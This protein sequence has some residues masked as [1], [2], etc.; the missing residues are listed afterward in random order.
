ME[1]A[2]CALH[3]RRHRPPA[4]IN[5][6][7][8]HNADAQYTVRLGGW[9]YGRL[10]IC[11][12]FGLYQYRTCIDVRHRGDVSMK[13]KYLLVVNS[14]FCLKQR[15]GSEREIVAALR[16]GRCPRSVAGRMHQ[17]LQMQR[18]ARRGVACLTTPAASRTVAQLPFPG[19]RRRRGKPLVRQIIGTQRNK[20]NALSAWIHA[21]PA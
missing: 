19:D 18:H 21:Q 7:D 8:V 6:K 10:R 12:L 5:L 9:Q 2:C 20:S 11:R 15:P 1:A 14:R 17:Q 16:R 4:A 13:K 3:R